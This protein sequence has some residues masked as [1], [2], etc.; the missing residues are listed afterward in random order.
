MDHW[1]QNRGL[2][3][4]VPALRLPG[5]GSIERCGGGGGDRQ[6]GICGDLA[7]RGDGG[8]PRLH[9]GRYDVPVAAA[10]LGDDRDRRRLAVSAAVRRMR[11]RPARAGE[12]A[13][14]EIR[15]S[16]HCWTGDHPWCCMRGCECFCHALGQP[17]D[18]SHL[19]SERASSRV[20]RQI[21]SETRARARAW[22]FSTRHGIV[23]D[24]R[25]LE[26]E[27]PPTLETT[28]TA[29]SC[30]AGKTQSRAARLAE[31]H[32]GNPSRTRGLRRRGQA[33]VRARAAG[34]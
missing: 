34:G 33:L 30:R 23:R 21:A 29:A 22:V 18:D 27:S 9:V 10:P 11:R 31:A 8:N 24:P 2:V 13:F 7:R 3:T 15:K 17:L 28:R 20:I 5:A 16:L 12:A 4:A 26:G 14:P 19:V 6:G 32:G 1:G 25:S